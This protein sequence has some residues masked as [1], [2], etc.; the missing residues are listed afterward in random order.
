VFAHLYEACMDRNLP[1]GLAPNI[2]VSLVMLPEECRGLLNHPEA[3]SRAETKRRLTAK[4]FAAQFYAR[5]RVSSLTKT[6]FRPQ[7]VQ[8]ESVC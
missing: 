5:R 4:A 1:I 6:F 3:Y 2:H 7:V 8:R